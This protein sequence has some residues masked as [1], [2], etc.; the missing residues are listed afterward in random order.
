MAVA[1][2][3]LELRP[4]TATSAV[5]LQKQPET[6]VSHCE[7]S[8]TF[9]LL[10]TRI[11]HCRNLRPLGKDMAAN[12]TI[13]V[14]VP[15]SPFTPKKLADAKHCL[16]A[17]SVDDLMKWWPGQPHHP[18]LHAQKVKSIQR[19]LDWKR[20][21]KIAAYLLQEE[22]VDAP[23]RLQEFFSPI[24]EPKAHEPGR[25]WPP[26]VPGKVNFDR[27]EYPLFSNV[28]IHV[29]GAKISPTKPVEGAG[30]GKAAN[31][32]FDE[33]DSALNFNVIDGQH[34]INGA[35]FALC[36]KR[37]M[38]KNQ[39]LVWE[40]P[41]EVFWISIPSETH[42]STSPNIYRREFQSEKGRSFA[43]RRSVSDGA[44]RSRLYG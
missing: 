11:L 6:E 26:R 34:R 16:A 20:V 22:I 1:P 17:L 21:A 41:A 14:I 29:N 15:E 31:L 43:R 30:K 5:N 37:E 3:P 40:I 7:D 39:N 18:D 32:L 8:A 19:S 33:N 35:Y 13:S 36:L 12:K 44:G 23:Q 42:R 27:S 10:L 2:Y 28:L 4:A 38:D 9:N 25:V 24:Y